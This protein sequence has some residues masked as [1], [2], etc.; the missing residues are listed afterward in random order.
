MS[1]HHTI[2]PTHLIRGGLRRILG[3]CKLESLSDGACNA[4]DCCSQGPEL[5]V[6]PDRS[7]IHSAVILHNKEDRPTV[8]NLFS[9]RLKR[10]P[11]HRESRVPIAPP[12]LL[13]PPK[14][15]LERSPTSHL[16]SRRMMPRIQTCV[17]PIS[18]VIEWLVSIAMSVC[19]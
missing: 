16:S 19:D 5:H 17:S 13:T 9:I 8:R 11:P 2:F 15:R 3:S 10:R 7:C 4:F 12:N 1:P 14:S 6:G 18:L